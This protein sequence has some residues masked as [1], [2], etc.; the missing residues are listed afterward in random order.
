M[1]TREVKEYLGRL[2]IT[3]FVFNSNM[4]HPPP[5]WFVKTQMWHVWWSLRICIYLFT[6]DQFLKLISFV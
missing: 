3:P 6:E 5:G 4:L 1:F 2:R